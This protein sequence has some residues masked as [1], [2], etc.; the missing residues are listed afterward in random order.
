MDKLEKLK[1][2]RKFFDKNSNVP[3][4]YLVFVF[5][6]VVGAYA[7]EFNYEILGGVCGFLAFA[8]V[9]CC[10]LN[11]INAIVFKI[12]DKKIQKIEIEASKKDVHLNEDK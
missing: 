11:I 7:Y 10:I 6:L 4:N 12:L 5:C 2:W 8:E 9:V 1:K 3:C